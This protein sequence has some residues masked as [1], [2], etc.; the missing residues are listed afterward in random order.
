MPAKCLRNVPASMPLVARADSAMGRA[1]WLLIGAVVCLPQHSQ[2]DERCLEAKALRGNVKTVLISKGGVSSDTGAQRNAPHLWERFDVSRDRRTITVVQYSADDFAVLPLFNLW[3]TIICEFDDSGRL[4]KSRLKLND[5]T[6]YT[7]VETTYD[8]QGRQVAVRSRSRNPELTGDATYEYSGNAV[9]ARFHRGNP[10]TTTTERDTSGR[11]TREIRNDQKDNIELSNVE[12]R[13][14]TNTVQMLG[15]E[16]ETNWR[17]TR[18][19][20]AMGNIV[21]STSQGVGYE[22]RNI[23]RFE[24]DPQGNWIRRVSTMYSSTSQPPRISDL[25]VRHISYWP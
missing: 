25:V 9:T 17:I 5:L 13:Y 7:T 16:N 4:V 19:L 1:L 14:G 24:Y 6:T 10:T 11:I 22:S 23:S 20:D 3:S 15:R 18:K 12:Y 2:A 8:A 21:E